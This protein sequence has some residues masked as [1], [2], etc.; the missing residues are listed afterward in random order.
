MA[1]SNI[2]QEQTGAVGFQ[3]LLPTAK[4]A[5][6]NEV[7]SW[8]GV[9]CSLIREGA[10]IR[11]IDKKAAAS[12]AAIDTLALA[13]DWRPELPP[14]DREMNYILGLDYSDKKLRLRAIVAR[15]YGEAERTVDAYANDVNRHKRLKKDVAWLAKAL[16]QLTQTLPRM[17][18][19]CNQLIAQTADYKATLTSEAARCLKSAA[20]IL[21]LARKQ[22]TPKGRP[23]NVGQ[24]FLVTRL[25]EAFAH[26]T[27]HKP[28]FYW[29]SKAGVAADHWR[30]LLQYSFALAGLSTTPETFNSAF[31]RIPTGRRDDLRSIADGSERA[32]TEP[33]D[34]RSLA[35]TGYQLDYMAIRDDGP[36]DGRWRVP[37]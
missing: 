16:P 24:T 34:H 10:P 18:A 20:E 6:A 5:S 28:T 15:A 2:R 11:E 32:A 23:P 3:R 4:A 1:L 37:I 7:R 21:D 27:R 29:A 31:R 12:L 25:A 26:S 35:S 9:R 36:V 17:A 8:L 30:T 33:L 13:V 19:T 14:M 22:S